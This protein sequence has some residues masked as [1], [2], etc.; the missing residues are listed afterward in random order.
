[1]FSIEHWNVTPDIIA[2]A[3]GM[4]SGYSPLAA[5][6]AKN[7]IWESLEDNNSPIRAGHTLSHNPVSAAVGVSVINYLIKNNLVEKSAENGSYFLEKL[8]EEIL[9]IGI[10]GDVRGK[11][12]MLGF[13]IVK[14]KKTKE[15][16]PPEDLMSKKIVMEAFKRGLVIY[17]CNGSVDGYTGDMILVAPP[18]I[19]N[20][21]QIDEIIDILQDSIQAC[22]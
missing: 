8:K 22:M 9:D 3:K 12:L 10:V 15:P 2:T 4:S 16:F 21:D 18:L 7:Q 19:I 17:P 14:D 1:M 11:G 20:K 13:E 5:V 6:V